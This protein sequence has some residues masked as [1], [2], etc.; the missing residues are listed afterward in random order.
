MSIHVQKRFI[1]LQELLHHPFLSC[2]NLEKAFYTPKEELKETFADLSVMETVTEP[3]DYVRGGGPYLLEEAVERLFQR[4]LKH[5]MSEPPKKQTAYVYSEKEATMPK[6]DK[7]REALA[8]KKVQATDATV[9]NKTTVPGIMRSR[10]T[11]V[12]GGR[13]KCIQ[14]GRKKKDRGGKV[15]VN[16]DKIHSGKAAPQNKNN[17]PAKK[18]HLIKIS[19]LK[20]SV[21]ESIFLS[22]LLMVEPK[23]VIR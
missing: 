16:K 17:E 15:N 6:G 10:S 14:K 7:I 20:G 3:P 18:K 2:V 12:R 21:N 5:T 13:P 4:H 8:T 23:I 19:E 22:I 11:I 9:Q 1:C